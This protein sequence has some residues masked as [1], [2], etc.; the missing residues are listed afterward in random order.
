M[1]KHLAPRSRRIFFALAGLAIAVAGYAGM[2][3]TPSSHATASRAGAHGP[4]V[5]VCPGTI[6]HC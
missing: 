6:Y 4:V 5:E 2:T 1:R 3:L